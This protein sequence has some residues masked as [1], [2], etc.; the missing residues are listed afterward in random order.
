MNHHVS[1][2]GYGTG[3]VWVLI[4]A[5]LNGFVVLCRSLSTHGL[6][7]PLAPDLFSWP[8]PLTR[9]G[10]GIQCAAYAAAAVA[11]VFVVV[12]W[13]NGLLCEECRCAPPEPHAPPLGNQR[14]K[15]PRQAR[16]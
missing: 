11:A 1:L 9:I 8:Q 6:S 3:L 10:V 13:A 5:A 2:H 7:K 12:F 16:E 15:L 14:K 4:I